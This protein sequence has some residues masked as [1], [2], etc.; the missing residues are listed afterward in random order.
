MKHL[1]IVDDSTGE[2]IE[3]IHFSGGYNIQ[4]TTYEDN[5]KIHH[6]TAL[7]NAK[8]GY[9]YWIKN[10]FY[11]PIAYKLTKNFEYFKG[12]RPEKIL[13]IEDQDYVGNEMEKPDWIMRI[14]KANAQLTEY[15]GYEWIVESREFWMERLSNEQV[16][17][18]IYSMLRYIDG[19]KLKKE[20]VCGWNELIGTLGYGWEYTKTPIP[21]LLDGFD[22]SDFRQLRKA[23]KQISMFDRK[24]YEES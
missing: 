17:A 21:N 14:K 1:T 22:K 6:V 11:R 18:F 19:D 7:D 23:D 15:T 2:E 16:V 12:I 13:F 5:G 3:N 10:E 4:Y 20:D 8:Y 9:K 24:Y